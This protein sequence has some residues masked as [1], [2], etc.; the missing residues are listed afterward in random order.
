M[1]MTTHDHIQEALALY[2]AETNAQRRCHWLRWA[3][4]W[5]VKETGQ[6]GKRA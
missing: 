2:R 1:Q 6:C 5:Y 3:L 4:W